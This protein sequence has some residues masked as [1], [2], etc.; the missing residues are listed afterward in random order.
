MDRKR[1]QQILIL[2]YSKQ[3]WRST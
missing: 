1:S 2:R 3:Y